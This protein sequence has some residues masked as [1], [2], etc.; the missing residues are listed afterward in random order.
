MRKFWTDAKGWAPNETAEM[1]NKSR[2]DWQVSLSKCLKIWIVEPHD[3]NESGKLILAWVN[4]GSLVEG[5][6]KLFLSVWNHDYKR[7]VEAIKVKGDLVEPDS[8][9]LDQMRK[10]FKKSV[11]L[12][13]EEVWDSWILKIQQ[14]RNA[15]HA[16]K[17]R[18]IG[19]F[20]EFYDDVRKYR[21]FLLFINDRLI[22]PND[23]IYKPREEPSFR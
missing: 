6:M 4:L 8:L 15:V 21:E 12:K 5:T 19:T 9:Q 17:N 10:F 13:D 3:D 16:Y 14:R 1:L 18:D 2:L 11:W 23:E 7:D 20:E 22:Y